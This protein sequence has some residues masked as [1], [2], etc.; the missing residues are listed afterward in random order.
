MDF[1]A[2]KQI[3]ISKAQAMGIKEYELY[4]QAGQSTS[5]FVIPCFAYRYRLAGKIK[6]PWR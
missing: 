1:N 6:I 5:T 4:Y 2:F 3:V